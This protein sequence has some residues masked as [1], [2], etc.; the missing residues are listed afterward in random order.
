MTIN[1]INPAE[2]GGGGGGGEE[3]GEISWSRRVPCVNFATF[4]L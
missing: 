3:R 2:A 1:L 4:L